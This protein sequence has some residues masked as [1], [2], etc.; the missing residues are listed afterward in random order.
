MPETRVE[1]AFFVL[2][3]VAIA[4]LAVLVARSWH[5]AGATAASKVSSVASATPTTTRAAAT[6]RVATTARVAIA[7]TPSKPLPAATTGT[8]VAPHGSS[9]T[10]S[11]ATVELVLR[12][13]R[14]DS[15][16]EVRSASSTGAVLYFGTLSSGRSKTFRARSLWVRFGAASNLDARLNGN[17][18]R[19]PAGTYSAL[20]G[21]DGL[22]QVRG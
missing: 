8:T 14:G 1:R 12:A 11:P 22:R 20:I 21:V 2:G 15:W 18:L 10:A 13:A 7:T 16:L 6:T 4:V 9:S 3:L 17:A 5:D 19:L